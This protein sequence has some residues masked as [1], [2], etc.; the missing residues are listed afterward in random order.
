MRRRRPLKYALPARAQSSEVEAAQMRN[1]ALNRRFG[2]DTTIA[3]LLLHRI[4]LPVWSG[5]QRQAE[6]CH[7]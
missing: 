5:P 2:R 6:L 4:R 1:L 7:L 3:M